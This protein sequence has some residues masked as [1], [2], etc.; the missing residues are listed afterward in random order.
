M[1]APRSAPR[2]PTDDNLHAIHRCDRR[3]AEIKADSLRVLLAVAAAPFAASLV[4]ILVLA[5]RP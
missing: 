1:S 3:L 2:R 5:V 4:S